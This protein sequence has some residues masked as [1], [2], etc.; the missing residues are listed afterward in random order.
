MKKLIQY[1]AV[2]VLCAFAVS[3]AG[4]AANSHSVGGNATWRTPKNITVYTLDSANYKTDDTIGATYCNYYG[5]FALSPDPSR[6]MFKGFRCLVATGTLGATETLSVEYSVLP[7]FKYADTLKSKFVAF[8]S[9]K[10]AAGCGGT[11]VK[12]DTLPGSSIIFKLKC[13]ANSTT[14][15]IA[16]PVKIHMLSNSSEVIDVKR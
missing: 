6:P 9:I 5:P 7:S 16:K 3:L 8:D 15:E 10:A 13:L 1:L 14:A 4:S 2:T 11:Y 12:L